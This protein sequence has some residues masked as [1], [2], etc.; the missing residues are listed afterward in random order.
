MIKIHS[1]KYACFLHSKEG[2]IDNILLLYF[3]RILQKTFTI[4]RIN[5]HP[6]V[7]VPCSSFLMHDRQKYQIIFMDTLFIDNMTHFII[8]LYVDLNYWTTNIYKYEYIVYKYYRNIG[9]FYSKYVP[10]YHACYTNTH[11]RK[12]KNTTKNIAI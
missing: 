7:S 6:L 4:I 8:Y 11:S 10:C 3:C 9:I 12:N 5:I 1:S 2:K